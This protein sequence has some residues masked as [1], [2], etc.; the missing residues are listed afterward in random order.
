MKVGDHDWQCGRNCGV[1]RSGVGAGVALILGAVGVG[2]GGKMALALRVVN[3]SKNLVN[4][5]KKVV[6]SYRECS[7]EFKKV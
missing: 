5:S 6:V 1:A 3:G 4:M 2:A 7:K